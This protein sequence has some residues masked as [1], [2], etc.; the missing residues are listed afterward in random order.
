MLFNSFLQT[1]LLKFIVNKFMFTLIFNGTSFN[2]ELNTFNNM[3][4]LGWSMLRV[5][6]Y[7]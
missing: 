3:Q 2:H 4:L 1:L 5:H 6:V 7:V